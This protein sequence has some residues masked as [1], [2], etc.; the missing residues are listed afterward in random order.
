MVPPTRKDAGA[1]NQTWRLGADNGFGSIIVRSCSR[2]YWT[3][4]L[5][6]NV[7]SKTNKSPPARRITTSDWGEASRRSHMR[8]LR[9]C[10]LRIIGRYFSTDHE[11]SQIT[12]RHCWTH[13]SEWPEQVMEASMSIENVTPIRAGAKS[14]SS[15]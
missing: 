9:M 2:V 6:A 12:R 4:Q 13:F 7:P 5:I 1:G 14:P 10:W 8:T 11:T 3:V 15:N